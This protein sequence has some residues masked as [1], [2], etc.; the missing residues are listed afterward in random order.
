MSLI[1]HQILNWKREIIFADLVIPHSKHNIDIDMKKWYKIQYGIFID[2]KQ[3]NSY[4]EV[5]N[6]VSLQK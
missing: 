4:S 1:D 6:V 2:L 5:V 3:S